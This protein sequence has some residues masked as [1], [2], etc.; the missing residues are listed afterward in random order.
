M[1]RLTGH[2]LSTS[3]SWSMRLKSAIGAL[4]PTLHGESYMRFH[5][6]RLRPNDRRTPAPHP[7]AD[8]EVRQACKRTMRFSVI[9]A[10]MNDGLGHTATILYRQTR[11]CVSKALD[12]DLRP[13]TW[14]FNTRLNTELQQRATALVLDVHRTVSERWFTRYMAFAIHQPRTPDPW[15]AVLATA[16]GGFAR[17]RPGG[18]PTPDV[19]AR[20]QATFRTEPSAAR[21]GRDP[22]ESSPSPELPELVAAYPPERHRA[23]R[24]RPAPT[25][26]RISAGSDARPS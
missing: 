13:L 10:F 3:W 22:F 12:E 20:F 19:D 15:L 21:I 16:P 6:I 24:P 11:A 23:A 7:E 4:A 17:Q 26:R 1:A 9:V 14:K 5:W 2:A 18:L 8:W 25:A